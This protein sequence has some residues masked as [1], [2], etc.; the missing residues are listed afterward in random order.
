M[1]QGHGKYRQYLSGSDG[2]FL[3]SLSLG[4]GVFAFWVSVNSETLALNTE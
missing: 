1:D 4:T 3:K 2:F